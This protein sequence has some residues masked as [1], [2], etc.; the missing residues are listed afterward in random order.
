M[1]TQSLIGRCA[2]CHI[3]GG[4]LRGAL[5]GVL[6]D[7]AVELL[8][9]AEVVVHR[10]DVRVRTAADLLGCRVAEAALGKHLARGLEQPLARIS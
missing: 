5:L 10:G 6:D 1:R 7:R 8:F 2:G 9:G 4:A 3:G